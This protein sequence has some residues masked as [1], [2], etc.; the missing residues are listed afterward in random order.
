MER[1]SHNCIEDTCLGY[2]FT[3]DDVILHDFSDKEIEFKS[4]A[5]NRQSA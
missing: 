2:N 5:V 3:A 1:H 4:P